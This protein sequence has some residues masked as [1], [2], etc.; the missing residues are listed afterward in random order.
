[1]PNPLIAQGTLN[2]LRGSVTWNAFPEL[3]VTAPYLGRQGIRLSLDGESTVF[4]ET[5]SG[6]VTSPEPY[7][8]ATLTL[9]LLKTQALANAYKA[10]LETLATIGD[11]T[12]RPDSA[13][14][15]P[16]E[17]VNCA[18]ESVREQ[19]FSGADA[20]FAVTLKGYYLVNA[21]LWDA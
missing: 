3:N 13:T 17:L 16:Y 7:M 8:M 10:R 20:G 19:D 5:M 14:L 15:S 6:A 18:I 21:S 9:N 4:L 12:I 2:R 1:M 11:G